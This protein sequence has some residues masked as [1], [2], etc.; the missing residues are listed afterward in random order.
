MFNEINNKFIYLGSINSRKPEELCVK[1]EPGEE[2]TPL[3]QSFCTFF[4]ELNFTN[5]RFY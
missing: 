1:H 4:H 5:P 2:E 3:K